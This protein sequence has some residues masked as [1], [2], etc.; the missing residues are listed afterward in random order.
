MSDSTQKLDALIVAAQ[1]GDKEAFAEIYEQ[2]FDQIY[3]YVFFR[4]NGVDSDDI[5][6]NIFIKVWINLEKYEKRD[7]SFSSWLYKIASNT[8]IDH[9]RAHR[10]LSQIDPSIADESEHSQPKKIAEQNVMA[11]KVRAAV[12]EL[13]EPY[14]Q[15]VSLKFLSGL[16]NTEIAEIMGEREGNIRVLQFRALKELKKIMEERGLSY[17]ML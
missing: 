5:V 8:I 9:H 17:E 16:T 2:F 7:V 4:T 6:E 1:N 3:K 10:P 13:R 11:E 12:N 15:V 14:R